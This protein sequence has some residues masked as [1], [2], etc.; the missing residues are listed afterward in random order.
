MSWGLCGTK[1]KLLAERFYSLL[2]GSVFA[3][4]L[5]CQIRSDNLKTA[6][7]V[8]DDTLFETETSWVK[9]SRLRRDRD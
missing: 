7:E 3:L 4:R 9:S 1:H 6:A 5:G 2:F 8:R